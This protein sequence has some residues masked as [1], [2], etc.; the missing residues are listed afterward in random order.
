MATVDRQNRGSYPFIPDSRVVFN[1]GLGGKL[2]TGHLILTG[3]I[4]VAGGTVNGTQVGDGG[5]VNLI[6]LIKITATPAAGSRYPGGDIV[7]CTPRSLLRYAICQHNGKFIAEQSSSVLGNGA[8]GTYQIYLSIPI[9]FADGNLRNEISTALNLDQGNYAS[10]Q[11]RVDTGDVTSC[12]VGNNATVTW[13]GLS[14]QWVDD[15][16]AVAG[17][18]LVR[19][20]EDHVML[21]ASTQLRAE[22]FALPQDGSYESWLLLSEQGAYATLSNALLQRVTVQGPTLNYDMFTQD[23]QQDDLDNEWFDP[24]QN[25]AGMAF[26]DFTGGVIAN[27]VPAAQLNAQFQVTNV[28]GANLDQIRFFTRRVFAPVPAQS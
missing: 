3:T 27:T 25:I 2:R 7:Y 11:V 14:V 26:I 28:S 16:V 5:P 4:V 6:K 9:Y 20:Q 19:Y 13:S 23:I 17:D 8:N 21:I 1:L 24:A 15:R 10:V 12:F 18:T 22:D